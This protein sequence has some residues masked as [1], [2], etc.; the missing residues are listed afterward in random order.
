MKSASYNRALS[1]P[2]IAQDMARPV[3]NTRPIADA[4]PDQTIPIGEVRIERRRIE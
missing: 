2:E 4:G 1:Q 3:V